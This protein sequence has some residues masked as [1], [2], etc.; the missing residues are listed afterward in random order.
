MPPLPEG[1][2]LLA[3]I[4]A[5]SPVPTFVIDRDHRVTHWNR[6]CE[7]II[8]IP[9]SAMLG[10]DRPWRAFYD[11]ER[12]VLAELVLAGDIDGMERLYGTKL[13]RSK[14]AEGA[15]EAEDYFPR[16]GRWLHFTA[17]PLRDPNGEIVGA[18]ETLQD[19]SERHRAEASLSEAKHQAEAAAQA[20]AEFLA[21]ISHEI[22]TPMNAVIG[23]THLLLKS[24]LSAKQREQIG[25]IQGA[26]KMLLGLI[27]DILDFSK[28][29]AG[30]MAL[31]ETPFKLDDCLDGLATVVLSQAQAKGLE[32]NYVVEPGVPQQL[33][34]DPLRFTQIL[35]NLVGNALK[36]TAEG[37]VTLFV[38]TIESSRA[39]VSLE[40]T[41]QDTGVGMSEE[42][43]QR[44]FQ[45]FSQADASITRKYGGTGLGL[46]ICKRLVELMGGEIWLSSEPGVGSTF[47]FTARFGIGEAPFPE[48]PPARGR[49]LIVDDSDITSMVLSRFFQQAGYQVTVATSG[50]ETLDI[51]GG[52]AH[53]DCI[54]LDDQLPDL[55][56]LAAAQAIRRISGQSPHLVLVTASDTTMLEKTPGFEAFNGILHKPVTAAHVQKLARRMSGMISFQPASRRQTTRLLGM[57][58]L[59]AEDIATNQYIAR[60]ILESLG[61]A[62]DIAADGRE[63]LAQLERHAYD[64]VLMDVQMPDMD[65]IEATRRIRADSR[66]HALPVVAMTAHAFDAERERCH[67]AGMN[68]FLTK[69]IDPDCLHDTLLRWRQLPAEAPAP[70]APA[71]TEAQEEPGLPVIA[72]I[73]TAE[74]LR[75]MMNKPKLYE[76]VLRDFHQR[77]REEAMHIRKCIAV[78]DH[79]TALR[80]A[81]TVKG[82]AGSIGASRLHAA[83]LT[84]EN[85]IGQNAQ[86]LTA[87]LEHFTGCLHEVIV[88]LAAVYEL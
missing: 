82:L 67:E 51:L 17:A 43:Q 54:A 31:E 12:P 18:I 79:E 27:N 70:V 47:S 84:L 76:R 32:V 7:Q 85:S 44:L 11:S 81:H 50:Q 39:Q 48:I 57:R 21:N 63:A 65:G 52:N 38:R 55:D 45:A 59:V 53:F 13:R 72:G 68:D 77:F 62:V 78:D 73:D 56:S 83:A 15:W 80:R 25:R 37:S 22:R 8:G 69:P 86:T 71:P 41:V 60:E 42:Q 87:D 3:G 5:G 14:L 29:E 19:V 40:V 34:G 66:W 88:G 1:L 33:I 30:R 46:T 49:A 64:L 4:L 35:V 23:L 10:T 28:I 36:F 2:D 58:V 20:K 61:V 6:A 9:A 16:S 26:G 74:G 24:E 75:R